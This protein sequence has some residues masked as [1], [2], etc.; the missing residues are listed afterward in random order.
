MEV[1]EKPPQKVRTEEGDQGEGKADLDPL[2]YRDAIAPAGEENDVRADADPEPYKDVEEGLGRAG[3]VG[4]TL[5]FGWR[6]HFH[7][8]I[9]SLL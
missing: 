3:P 5:L 2:G 6:G 8:A 1:V 7:L 4:L 9:T